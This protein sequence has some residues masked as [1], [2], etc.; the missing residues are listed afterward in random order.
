MNNRILRLAGL[1]GILTPPIGFGLVALS[2]S[3]APWFSWANNA[4]S[5]LGAKG[6]ESVIFNS[7]LP[8]TGAVMMMFSTGLFEMSKKNL[9]GTIG[10]VLYLLASFFLIGIGV[11]NINIRPWHFY[12]SVA[13]FVTLP[14]C[15]IVLGIF[16][17]LNNMKMY[18]TIA[19]FM[20]FLAAVIW[21]FPWK[22]VAIPEALSAAFVSV[23]QVS[24]AIWMY[25]REINEK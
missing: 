8:M 10:S 13:F 2:I 7:G 25:N 21:A 5:D 14:I 17:F 4:L 12:V 9:I 1:F 23:W 18:A 19:W 24:L 15:L 11:A 6:F 3:L 22:G 20:A 16:H